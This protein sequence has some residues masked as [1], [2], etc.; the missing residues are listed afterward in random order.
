M[1]ATRFIK[2][3]GCCSWCDDPRESSVAHTATRYVQALTVIWAK[4]SPAVA[5]EIPRRKFC[6]IN[7]TGEACVTGTS[8]SYVEAIAIGG[9][10][11]S[12]N[13]ILNVERFGYV[14]ANVDKNINQ[15][16]VPY[17]VN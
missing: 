9:T 2:L 15:T 13:N 1:G 5:E 17:D 12:C 14:Q 8:N 3:R 11:Y 16:N 4:D 6:S 7:G 10:R